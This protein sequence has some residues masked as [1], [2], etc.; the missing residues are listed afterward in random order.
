[1]FAT[2]FCKKAFVRHQWPKWEVESAGN[3]RVRDL[4]DPRQEERIKG[5][6]I[7][8]RRECENCGLVQLARTTVH[9]DI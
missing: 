7:I 9:A 4:R 3:V 8:Q 6:F 5:Q 2:L 1:M